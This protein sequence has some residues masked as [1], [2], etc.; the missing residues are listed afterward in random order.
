LIAK[1]D[2]GYRIPE[3]SQSQAD[4][5]GPIKSAGSIEYIPAPNITPAI[6]GCHCIIRADLSLKQVTPDLRI[7]CQDLLYG[8]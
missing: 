1:S 5:W 2:G 4:L 6:P 7:A 8:L 3:S